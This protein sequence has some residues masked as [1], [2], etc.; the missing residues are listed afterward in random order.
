MYG[1]TPGTPRDEIPGWMKAVLKPVE[2][3]PPVVAHESC[4]FNQQLP[5]AKTLLAKAIQEGSC[6]FIGEL[7]A[8]EVMN[9]ARHEYGDR[10]GAELWREFQA[11]MHGPSIRNWM[12]NGLTA[13][14]KPTDL[15]Y[16]MGYKITE[17]YYN[18]AEDKRQAIRDILEIKDFSA[19]LRQSRYGK[20][21]AR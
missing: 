7:I 12:Y 9:P 15:G 13:G 10:H 8:G 19:F 20:K 5:E 14:D 4:H 2:K 11:E 17:S 21:P 16:Y 3:L 18:N 6:D 1:S